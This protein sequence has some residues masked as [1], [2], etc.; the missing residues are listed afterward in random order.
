MARRSDHSR[1]QLYDLAL[2][3]AEAIVEA[4]GLRALTARNIA[5]AIGYSP[6][7]LYN[8]FANLDEMIL[9]LKGRTLERLHDRLAVT[10]LSGDA[11]ADIKRLLDG[12]LDFLKVHPHLWRVMFEHALPDSV[13]LPD[14]YTRKVEAVLALVE[15]ALAPLF[16][17]AD[18]DVRD[19]R[20]ADAARILW[21][22]LHGICSL[23]E[24]GKL[25]VVSNRPL[26]QM[27]EGLVEN[28]VAGLRVTAQAALRDAAL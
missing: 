4:D 2:D 25:Q 21:A 6:G 13:S 10:V 9:H 1:E 28:F 12:Y 24:A 14:W 11:E 5:E 19:D 7:T 17:E 18:A 16:D 15:T 8:L 20:C 23:A 26:R 22:G 27:A 3:A